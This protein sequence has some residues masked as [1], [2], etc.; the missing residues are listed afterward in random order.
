MEIW[1][2]VIGFENDYEISN[3]GNLR[4]KERLVKHYRGGLRKYKSS[5]KNQRLNQNGYKRCNLKKDGQRFDFVIHQLVAKSF[6][7]NE[8][9]KCFVNH[10]NGIKT[11]N[12][13][14]NLEWVT[15]SENTIHAVKNRLIKTKLTDKE[16]L[17]ISKNNL[18]TRKLAKIYNVSASIIWRIKNKTSYKHLW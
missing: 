3:L 18:S 4:S 7:K 6:I 17:E 1:K 13:V 16:V 9:D 12:R 10:I 8:N 2:D 5:L 14:E 11:D 15:L